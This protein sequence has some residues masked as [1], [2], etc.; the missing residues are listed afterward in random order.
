MFTAVLFAAALTASGPSEPETIR[1][2]VARLDRSAIV[3]V[4]KERICG[5]RPLASFYSRREFKPAWNA[6]DAALLLDIV[7]NASDH[8]LQPGDYH[9]DAIERLT[10][11]PSRAAERDLLLTDAFLLF[12]SHLLSG[13]VDAENIVP[14]WCLTPRTHDLA[15]ALDTALDAGDVTTVLGGLSP[16]HPAYHRLRMALADY[17]A[18]AARGGWMPV[19]KGPAMRRGDSGPRVDHLVQRLFATRDI[20]TIAPA[21]DDVVEAA[22]RRFQH[23]H[24]LEED[25]VAGVRTIAALDV[26]VEER[27]RQLELNLERWRWL[28]ETL[29]SRYALIDIPSFS[30]Q[31]IENGRTVLEMRIVVGKDYQRTP[32]F[33]SEIGEVVFSPYWNVPASIAAKEIWPRVSRDRGY[34]AR[35]HMEV[36]SS[37]RIRQTPGPW[38]ALGR[39]KFLF[40]NPHGVYL[41][42]TPAKSLFARA[43]RAF[44]HGCMRIEQPVEL[45]EY[46]LRDTGLTR[47][48]II[49]RSESGIEKTVKVLHPLPLHVLYWTAL[50]DESGVVHFTPDIYSRDAALDAAMRQAPEDV[51]E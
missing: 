17:R 45:A 14:T 44:S 37:G 3:V 33:S 18:L 50:V 32:V 28:P 7:R 9:V 46:L 13:K 22:V 27:I 39:L 20:D 36:L 35:E 47:E 43:V 49:A 12:G 31:V 38:N 24:S 21:F 48:E 6:A 34:L 2:T 29:G 51:D 1:E 10:G 41:H 11:N 40:P 19:G 30:L 8:G 5:S 16:D 4:E 25:G 15:A 26:P 23:R 42:D